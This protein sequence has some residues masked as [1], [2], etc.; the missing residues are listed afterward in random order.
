M[1]LKRSAFLLLIGLW[2]HPGALHAQAPQGKGEDDIQVS[3]EKKGR[4]LLLTDSTVP[5]KLALALSEALEAEAEVLSEHGYLREARSRGL[6]PTS[7]DAYRQILVEQGIHLVI[8]AH[9]ERVRGKRVLRLRYHEGREGI[10]LLEEDHELA[11]VRLSELTR[12]RMLAEVRLALASI[13]QE[14][15][16]AQKAEEAETSA[17]QGATPSS[18]IHIG[19]SVGFGV[20]T[21][22]FELPA[23][24]SPVRLST[25]AFPATALALRTTYEPRAQGQWRIFGELRYA[26]SLGLRTNDVRPD[27][28]VRETN[29]RSQRVDLAAGL[30]YR[31]RE[32]ADAISFEGQFGWS[33][34][35]FTS[36][37][38]VTLPDYGLS[39]PLLKGGV[40]FPF[41]GDKLRLLV[42][43]EIHW[44]ALVDGDLKRGGVSSMGVALG[45]EG[46]LQWQIIRVLGLELLYRE[47]HAILGADRGKARDVERY[48]ILSAIYQP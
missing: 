32:A 18:A 3:R 33:F 12:D 42:G 26:S 13:L 7:R 9:R 47:S 25:S 4:V 6:D 37:A 40:W 16:S 10:L 5:A 30:V 14:Q 38:S 1:S 17:Q 35:L 19:L 41:K 20:G 15:P 36:D 24:P 27:G 43:P 34:R 45:G 21:R 31:L 46:K 8:H 28:T 2:V 11:G 48:G 29:S 22:A 44:L 23:L 39:G